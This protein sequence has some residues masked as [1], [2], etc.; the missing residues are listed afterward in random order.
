M[1][2]EI[3][4]KGGLNTLGFHEC[5]LKLFVVC[6]ENIDGSQNLKNDLL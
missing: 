5:S 3:K 2:K 4:M 1:K 6:F